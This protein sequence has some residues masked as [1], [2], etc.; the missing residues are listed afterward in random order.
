MAFF[1]PNYL[2]GYLWYVTV[3]PLLPTPTPPSLPVKDACLMYGYLPTPILGKDAC[4]VSLWYPHEGCLQYGT[5]APLVCIC[6][7]ISLLE[8]LAFAA[9]LPGVGWEPL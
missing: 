4:S 1:P 5:A 7:L 8:H 2:E 3:V 9:G 6:P